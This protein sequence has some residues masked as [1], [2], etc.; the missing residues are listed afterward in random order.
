MADDGQLLFMENEHYSLVDALPYIDTQLGQTEVAQQVKA[1][2]DEEM[3]NFVARDY[4][5]SL[6]APEL[7]L[8]STE[9]M[10]REFARIEAGQPMGGM[11][12]TKYKVDQ[13]QGN[14]AQDH[15]AWKVLAD[16]VQSQLEYS[17]LRIANL[18]M[19]ERWGGKAWVAHSTMVRATERIV[20]TEASGVRSVREE[21]NKKRKLDQ[22]SCG[23]EL[24]KLSRELEQYQQ[25]NSVVV[26]ALHTLEGEVKRLRQAATDRGVVLEGELAEDG[27]EKVATTTDA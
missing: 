5:A 2:I 26:A 20:A 18:E 22:V 23:N 7:P 11:D 3:D 8:L 24:R 14:S 10:K 13:P 17:R 1:M 12:P 21:V 27:A 25:D 4:L 6:P 9:A 15:G 16:K 19:L